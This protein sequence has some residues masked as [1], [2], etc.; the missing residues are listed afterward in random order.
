MVEIEVG[1]IGGGV[2]VDED[3]LASFRFLVHQRDAREGVPADEGFGGDVVP[4]GMANIQNVMVLVVG[5]ER[6]QRQRQGHRCGAP[7]YRAGH[8]VPDGGRGGEDDRGGQHGA[9]AIE[10]AQQ[11]HQQQAAGGGAE[12][13]EKVDPVDAFHGLGNG[14]RDDGAGDEERQGGRKVDG[15]QLPERAPAQFAHVA[16]LG[17]DRHQRHHHQQAIER[18]QPAEFQKQRRLPACHHVGEHPAGAQAEQGDRDR[19]KREVVVEHHGK[20]AR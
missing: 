1:D 17:Q 8:A 4:L 10:H 16:L 15:R 13:V 9:F 3:G 14:Q 20:N 6:H 7:V 11:A 19:Q 5:D 18:A 12:Q 2:G